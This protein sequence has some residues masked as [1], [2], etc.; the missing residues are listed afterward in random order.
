MLA[1]TAGDGTWQSTTKQ[2]AVAA[3]ALHVAMSSPVENTL[4]VHP[5]S[6]P[7]RPVYPA[8]I[9][10]DVPIVGNNLALIFQLLFSFFRSQRLLMSLF[11]SHFE[12]SAQ[13]SR[14]V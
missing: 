13:F 10:P 2:V 3:F 1:G 14:G 9:A 8:F 7:R 12:R 6:R 4:V 5:R 11:A